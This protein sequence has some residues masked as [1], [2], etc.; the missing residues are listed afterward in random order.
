MQD[1]QHDLWDDMFWCD[2]IDVVASPCVLQFHVPLT[3]FFRCQVKAIALVCNVVVL[4]EPGCRQSTA[5]HVPQMRRDELTRIEGCSRRR[6]RYHFHCGPGNTVLLSQ[7]V[8][9]LS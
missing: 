2:E 9:S 5:C 6:I 7:T 1:G 4:T 3:K 8:S